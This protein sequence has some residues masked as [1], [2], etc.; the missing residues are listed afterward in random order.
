[1]QGVEGRPGDGR[2]LE[3]DEPHVATVRSTSGGAPSQ[4]GS[5][6]GTPPYMSPE[7]A[8]GEVEGLDEQTDVFALGAILCEILTG[9]RP[10]EGTRRGAPGAAV[11]GRLDAAFSRLDSSRAERELVRLAKRCLDPSRAE[12]PR[13]AGVL[14]REVAG[15]LATVGERARAAEVAAA[16]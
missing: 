13:N 1:H 9:R 3:A 6:I 10:Y 7:Q 5:V 12:R 4:S 16:E 8:R 15:F 11:E 2:G 14:A